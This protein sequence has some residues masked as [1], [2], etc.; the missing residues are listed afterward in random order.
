MYGMNNE[1]IAMKLAQARQNELANEARHV[2][3]V[4]VGTEREKLNII[5]RLLR[6]SQP[7]R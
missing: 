4:L 6:E 2:H 5:T 3:V 1:Y 7:S